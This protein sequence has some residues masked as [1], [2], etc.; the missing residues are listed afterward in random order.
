MRSRDE[1][2]QSFVHA[3]AEL[4]PNR[5]TAPCLRPSRGEQFA[6]GGPAGL[7]RKKGHHNMHNNRMLNR[8]IAGALLT[9]CVA[10]AGLGLAS[11]GA[12][13]E[14]GLTPLV[15]QMDD[16]GDQPP[17]PEPAPPPPPPPQAVLGPLLAGPMP[18]AAREQAVLRPRSAAAPRVPPPGRP[19][20]AAAPAAIRRYGSPSAGRGSALAPVRP[21]RHCPLRL[22]GDGQRRVHAQ[23]GGTPPSR[24]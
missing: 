23:V 17:P 14:P 4:A 21:Q 12:Q 19:G 3:A 20:A 22:G 9:G 8:I 5:A 10:I 13:A 24:P 16:P 6:R 2:I 11:G 1:A 15:W 18:A 7:P